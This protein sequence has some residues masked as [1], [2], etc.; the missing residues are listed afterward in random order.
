M[1]LWSALGRKQVY[2]MLSAS[3]SSDCVSQDINV[4]TH[5][6]EFCGVGKRI[7]PDVM[8]ALDQQIEQA[9]TADNKILKKQLKRRLVDMYPKG[10]PR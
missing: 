10:C 3:A 2:S 6:K 7:S 5:R 9:K 8:A 1:Y 4:K